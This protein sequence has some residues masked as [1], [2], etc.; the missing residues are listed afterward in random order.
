VSEQR[1]NLVRLNGF[2]M[3]IVAAAA[4]AILASFL[5]GNEPNRFVFTTMPWAM[6]AGTVGSFFM[7]RAI[8]RLEMN[9]NG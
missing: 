8:R 7:R 5:T 4:F 3:G 9:N 1:D 2:F 6:V